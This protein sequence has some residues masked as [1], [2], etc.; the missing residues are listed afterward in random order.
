MLEQKEH[1]FEDFEAVL[2]LLSESKISRPER[3]AIIGGSNGGLLVAA[4]VTREPQLFAAAIANVGL[5]DMLRY[6][7]FPPAQI[8]A[9]EFGDP[10]QPDAARWL[11]AYSPYHRVTAGKR[12]PAVLIESADHDTRVHWAHSTKLAARLQEA[13]AGER[14]V[15]FFLER[16]QGHGAGT[17]LRD[18][19]TQYSR[20]YAFIESQLGVK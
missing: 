8:W 2:R 15:Y 16:Q 1:V 13:Q 3:I 14:P 20:A 6:P 19:V 7:L 12:Y 18:L 11:H 10:S 5:Y 4:A 17:R 9:S